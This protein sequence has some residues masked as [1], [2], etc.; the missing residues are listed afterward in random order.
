MQAGFPVTMHRAEGD[1]LAGPNRPHVIESLQHAGEGTISV[2]G[3][4]I[5]SGT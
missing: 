5:A 2:T 4:V 3:P 1:V